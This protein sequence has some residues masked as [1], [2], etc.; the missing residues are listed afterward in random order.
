LL[1]AAFMGAL[2]AQLSATYNSAASL[3]AMDF[4]RKFRPN[5]AEAVLVKW[6][7]IAAA[8]CMVASIVCAPQISR[9]PSLWQY[10][11]TVLAYSTPPAVVLFLG[12][13]LSERVDSRGAIAAIVTGNAVGA[14]L[15]AMEMLGLVHIQFLNVAGI[16]F[17][18]AAVALVL[19]SH[20]PRTDA[21]AI[22]ARAFSADLA[23]GRARNFGVEGGVRYWAVAL[24]AVTS[25]I[26]LY[27]R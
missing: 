10:L 14:A 27:F 17:A 19:G 5:L 12:G 13:M 11:Q 2:M 23:L 18:V 3:I 20:A 4:A 22:G 9:F 21:S 7:R 16:V 15:F 1:L 6:G 8:G 24:L 25:L 26:V